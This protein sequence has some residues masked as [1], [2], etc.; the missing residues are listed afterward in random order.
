MQPRLKGPRLAI[1]TNAGGPARIAT[2]ALIAGGGQ[3]APL[4][5]ETIA[6]LY[7]ILPSPWKHSNPIDLLGDA[8]PNRYV[9]ALEVVARDP[10]TDGL[11]VILTPQ[12]MTDPTAT[13]EHLRQHAKISGKPVLASWMGGEAVEAGRQI[14]N[15]AGIPCYEYPD[16]AARV[17]TLMWGSSYNLQGLYETPNGPVDSETATNARESAEAIIAAVRRQG[18]TVLTEPESKQLLELYGIPTV[19]TRTATTEEQ[20]VALAAELGYPRS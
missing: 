1:L 7:C 4:W 2:A 5:R 19:P 3:L 6:A 9:K 20:A 17:F 16:T 8:D 12:A 15:Q 11:L 13:A 10:N 18:R 14:L